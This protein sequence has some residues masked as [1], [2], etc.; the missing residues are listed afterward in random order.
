[1]NFRKILYT[2]LALFLFLAANRLSAQDYECISTDPLTGQVTISWDWTSIYSQI[3]H[4][5]LLNRTIS[6]TWTDS[7]GFSSTAAAMTH[8]ILTVNGNNAQYLFLLR[9]VLTTP[10][11][12]QEVILSNIYLTV[13]PNTNS[14][15]VLNWNPIS[16]ATFGS[17][18]IQR[19]DNSNWRTIG[20]LAYSSAASPTTYNDTLSS[21]VFCTLSIVNYRILFQQT[22]VPCHS[23][24]NTAGGSFHDGTQPLNPTNDTISIYNDPTGLYT[25]CPII[26]WTG[27]PSPDVA[28]YIIYRYNGSFP[29]LD[30]IPKDSTVYLD[31]SVKT[32]Q[33]SS[34]Y[35]IAAIDS[36]GNVS[37]G[38][39][40]TVPHSIVLIVPDISPCDRKAHLSWTK[41]DNMPGG[42]GMLF[43]D[44]S[45]PAVLP[46]SLQLVIQSPL[47]RIPPFSSMVIPIHTLCVPILPQGQDPPPH[48]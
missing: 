41:Y 21:P 7:T 34:S 36:C 44:R 20:N 46:P 33:Q 39:F 6:G 4:Y 23:T 43:T 37:Y 47:I 31:R 17:F 32:C 18:L 5:E 19:F 16:A 25:G 10:G 8:T 28:G 22:G 13:V 38:T 12:K 2:I 30:T 3:D 26:G 40:S 35:A 24:S 42:L 29:V 27:S 1:M 15:A 48:A 45:T 9:A 11:S 14:I